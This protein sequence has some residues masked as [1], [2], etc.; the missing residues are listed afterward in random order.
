MLELRS[1]YI[2]VVKKN[3]AEDSLSKNI[4]NQKENDGEI[5]IKKLTN[6][7]SKGAV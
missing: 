7:P 1:H 2:D 4:S 6:H 5:E 3:A